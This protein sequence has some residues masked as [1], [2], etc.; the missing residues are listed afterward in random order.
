MKKFII[1]SDGAAR[2]NPGPSG[3]GVVIKDENGVIVREISEYI[4]ETTNNQAEYKA[5]LA[6]LHGALSLGAEAIE[7]FADSELMV[8]QIKGVYKVKNE[9][10]KP[11]F[12]E[13]RGLLQKIKAYG[14]KHVPREKNKEADRLANEAIDGHFKF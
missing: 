11:L 6:A 10:I 12:N 8:N 3:I 13:A 2:G 5:L 7:I 4:G 9:G 1:N 14:I